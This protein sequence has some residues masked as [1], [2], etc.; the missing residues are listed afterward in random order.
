[1][2]CPP[3]PHRPAP[4]PA[5]SRSATRYTKHPQHGTV[6]TPLALRS[7]HPCRQCP[8]SAAQR[9]ASLQPS[10]QPALCLVYPVPTPPRHCLLPSPFMQRQNLTGQISGKRDRTPPP[11]LPSCRGHPCTRQRCLGHRSVPALSLK[12]QVQN[13]LHIV[14]GNSSKL[15]AQAWTFALWPGFWHLYCRNWSSANAKFGFA[16][17]SQHLYVCG[18]THVRQI[19]SAPCLFFHYHSIVIFP[20]YR[21]MFMIYNKMNHEAVLLYGC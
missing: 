9:Q 15:S 5:L 17:R 13:C 6:P 12:N 11:T 2:Q 20:C 4:S 8:C 14:V 19:L 21:D 18:K 10:Q 3:A 7:T 1:M 16:D